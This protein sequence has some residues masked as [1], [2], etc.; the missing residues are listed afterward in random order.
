MRGEPRF[1]S[2]MLDIAGTTAN[3]FA[4][5]ILYP[6]ML[7]PL[8][9][10]LA[11]DR[12]LKGA[13]V[14]LLSALLVTG[15]A[16]LFARL[17]V[18]IEPPRTAGSYLTIAAGAMLI[19]FFI[20]RSGAAPLAAA[21]AAPLETIVRRFGRLTLFLILAMALIQFAV[22][23][24]RYVFGVNS[25]FMQESI[26]YLHGAVFLLAA[27][28]ALLT[29]DHVRVDIFYRESSARF[30]ARVDFAG[31]YF[32]LFPFCLVAL[33]AAAPYVATSW[34]VH[35]GSTE[36]SGIQ[37]VFLLK[38]LIPLFLVLLAMAGFSLA[39]RAGQTL[40]GER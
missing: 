9:A 10:L 14:F 23:I 2:D 27:G 8:A 18:D 34:S 38:T 28:Y 31:A 19:A 16:W 4:I 25:I 24:L 6:L 20:A 11:G 5:G 40:R 29:D 15:G 26:T 7:L 3:G 1:H 30:K 13:A 12:K 33:W 35:E 37:A 17:A 22:V 39:T 32:L 21:I 36:Q